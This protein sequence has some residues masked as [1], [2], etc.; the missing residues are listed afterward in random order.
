MPGQ[1]RRQ[2]GVIREV[3]QVRRLREFGLTAAQQARD[4]YADQRGEFLDALRIGRRLQVFDDHRFHA[5][6]RQ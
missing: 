2:R 6:I 4:G 5:G 3:G 1:P